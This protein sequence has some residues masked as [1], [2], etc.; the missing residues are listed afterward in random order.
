MKGKTLSV[1]WVRQI[2]VPGA[3]IREVDMADGPALLATCPAMVRRHVG[4]R[5]RVTLQSAEE[6]IEW[7]H[8]DRLE[9]RRCGF[10]VVPTWSDRL[11]GVYHIWAVGDGGKTVG[12]EAG[13][14]FPF[15]G[16]PLFGLWTAAVLDYCVD[17]LGARRVET[18][19]AVDN[20]AGQAAL[21]R[22][23]AVREGVVAP[24]GNGRRSSPEVAWSILS[25]EWLERRAELPSA[26]VDLTYGASMEILNDEFDLPTSTKE[27]DEGHGLFLVAESSGA[28]RTA[29]D[30]P[31]CCAPPDASG[32][33]FPEE[34]Y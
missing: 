5:G 28:L 14:G 1:D 33:V 3:R 7:L 11:L 4:R 29:R 25:N 27:P 24:I 20:L 15:W 34:A 6:F 22:L 21:L 17:S 13:W 26:S 10:A 23:G 19:V 16:S 18:R 8:R 30:N 12:F 2:K 9:G 32:A 31:T